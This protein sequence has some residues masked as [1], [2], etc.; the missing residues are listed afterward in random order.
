MLMLMLKPFSSPSSMPNTKKCSHSK[1]GFPPLRNIRFVPPTLPRSPNSGFFPPARLSD[2]LSLRLSAR[3]S[4]AR[5]VLLWFA[6]MTLPETVRACF[7][8]PSTHSS[9]S[10]LRSSFFAL[11]PA[12]PT[13]L[14]VQDLWEEFV[15][16]TAPSSPIPG[17]PAKFGIGG[18]A[19]SFDKP[20]A[21]VFVGVVRGLAVGRPLLT[22]R[23]CLLIA[24]SGLVGEFRASDLLTSRPRT[25][26]LPSLAVRRP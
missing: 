1:T 24:L 20:G 2:L 17:V 15:D 5:G 7:I 14:P 23:S 22:R 8:M 13:S 9:F 11:G 4:P 3:S 6:V 19:S 26:N 25:S 21:M 16:G 18:T 10:P 12:R